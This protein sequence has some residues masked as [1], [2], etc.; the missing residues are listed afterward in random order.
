MSSNIEL[1]SYNHDF[2]QETPHFPQCRCNKGKNSLNYLLISPDDPES[3]HRVKNW[4]KGVRFPPSPNIVY[5]KLLYLASTLQDD[6]QISLDISRTFPQIDYFANGIGRLTLSR[7]LHAFC[8]YCPR[9]GYSQGMNYI[10]ATLLWHSNEVDAFWLFVVLIE[11][12]ELRDNFSEGFPGLNKHYHAIDF[13]ISNHLPQLYN[14]L[15]NLNIAVQ[16]FA[17]EWLVTLFTSSVPI[18]QS[19]QVL[20]KFFKNGWVFIYKLFLEITTRL[21]EKIMH[22]RSFAGILN[23]LKPSGVTD[24]QWNSFVKTMEKHKEKASWKK[25]THEAF[26]REIPE[27]FLNCMLHNAV[28][29]SQN[30]I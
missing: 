18:D 19:H 12:Y 30:N 1:C 2:I 27:H 14:H 26:Q 11:D 16:M 21:S 28:N 3:C 23:I 20:S 29:V 22:T 17:T 13:L 8:A 5:L 25:I 7:I 24:K 9:L 6:P 10:A 15:L 4:C